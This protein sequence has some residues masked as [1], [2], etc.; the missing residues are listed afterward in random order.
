MRTIVSFF[1]GIVVEKKR[2]RYISH[3]YANNHKF[4]VLV[5]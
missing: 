4:V 2:K 1:L 5:L 3:S